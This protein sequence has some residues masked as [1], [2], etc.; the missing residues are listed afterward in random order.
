MAIGSGLA[1]QFGIANETVVNTPVAVTT[2]TEGDTE[3][4]VARPNFTQGV[5]LAGGGLVPEAGRRLLTSMD[6]GG[7]FTFDIPN[8][9]LGKWMQA[10]MGSY[11]TTATVLVGSAYQQIHNLGSTDGKT[12]TFQKGI[13]DI[14]GTVNPLTFGGCKL[15]D[16][17]VSAAP[18]GRVNL[19]ATID[20]MSVAPTGAG[21][22]GLQTATYP[23]VGLFGFN[24]V[25]VSTFAAYTTVANLLTPTTPTA[26]TVR[27]LTLKGGQPKD[28]TR[29]GS[30]SA[31]KG[32]Q[33][34]NNF[35]PITGTIDVD[36]GVGAS[37]MAFYNQFVANT[38]IGIQVNVTGTLIG[39]SNYNQLQFTMPACFLEAGSTPTVTGPGVVTV[40]YPFTALKD[41]TGNALQV[42]IVSTDTTV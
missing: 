3:G 2:F 18:N 4:V 12:F 33:L 39:G 37:S 24:N 14:A 36:F 32:E 5:G 26:L 15:T 11:S 34:V 35:Q 23:A 20:A 7:P 30:G 25:T 1:A 13:P 42:Q 8:K 22:L 19:Q 41:A 40:S 6:G 31:T 17:T 29:W 27:N 16:W 38:S 10:M 9:G 21:A 28:T